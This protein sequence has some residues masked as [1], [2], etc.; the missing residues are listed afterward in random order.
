MTWTQTSET[1]WVGTADWLDA[2]VEITYD[3]RWGQYVS[4]VTTQGYKTLRAAKIAVARA[5][6]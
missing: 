6:H 5:T 4:D 3:A 1:E 2:P